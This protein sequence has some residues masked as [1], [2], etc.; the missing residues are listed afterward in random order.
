V[1]FEIEMEVVVGYLK[2]TIQLG[3][4]LPVERVNDIVE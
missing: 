1:V 4:F 2:P 3:N